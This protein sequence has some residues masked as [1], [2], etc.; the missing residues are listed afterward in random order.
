ML[1]LLL[2]SRAVSLN[3]SGGLRE[4]VISSLLTVQVR[5][6]IVELLLQIANLHLEL[7]LLGHV[8]VDL[9]LQL[10]L[11][12]LNAGDHVAHLVVH[13]HL[14]HFS[15]FRGRIEVHETEDLRVVL[16]KS[17]HINLQR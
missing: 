7:G 15:L 2:H 1:L 6:Q 16:V 5:G 13:D 4:L 12:L 10:F 9:L 14:V 11:L 3:L 8:I 17:V